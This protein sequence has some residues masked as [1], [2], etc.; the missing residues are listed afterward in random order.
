MSRSL[1]AEAPDEIVLKI[2]ENF[3]NTERQALAAL[4]LCCKK[5]HRII[6]PLL[7]TTFVQ[8]GPTALPF[9]LR[10]ISSDKNEHLRV[11]TKKIIVA[12]L[13]R[14]KKS[15]LPRMDMRSLTRENRTNMRSVIREAIDGPDA[16]EIGWD[17]ED[18]AFKKGY[19]E[20]LY[21]LA[22]AMLPKIESIE[23]TTPGWSLLNDNTF[24]PG[25]N[26]TFA[27]DQHF[28]QRICMR[29]A[30]DINSPYSL[31]K[32]HTISIR[33]P[34]H[35]D[36]NNDFEILPY[37]TSPGFQSVTK[38]S[39]H[40]SLLSLQPS[41]YTFTSNVTSLSLTECLGL[42]GFLKGFPLLERFEYAQ[43]RV[44]EDGTF[45]LVAPHILGALSHLKNT[46]QELKILVPLKGKQF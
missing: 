4:S 15:K 17:W 34:N 28:I 3:G 43:S 5:F 1:F 10:T 26:H 21:P 41:K 44:H 42:C 12:S 38:L 9:F 37:L 7:Y 30:R 22:L 35:G 24:P 19:W 33:A 23:L 32:L 25:R 6:Q 14:T 36:H 39:I 46:L 8:T 18:E 29:Q 45:P 27:F 31:S 2:S 20:A 11:Y 40:R 13:P 16:E